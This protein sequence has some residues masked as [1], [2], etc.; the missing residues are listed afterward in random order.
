MR[1]KNTGRFIYQ[2]KNLPIDEFMQ[3]NKARVERMFNCHDFCDQEW[4]W[5]KQVDKQQIELTTAHMKRK[6]NKYQ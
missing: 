2:N 4:F 5:T 1:L 6:Y 3:K